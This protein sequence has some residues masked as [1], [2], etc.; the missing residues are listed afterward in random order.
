[1]VASPKSSWDL[2]IRYIRSDLCLICAICASSSQNLYS[3]PLFDA[4]S[5]AS[6][7]AFSFNNRHPLSQQ[8]ISIQV[9]RVSN[10]SIS[11]YQILFKK[12]FSNLSRAHTSTLIILLP[13]TSKS[14]LF[15]IIY[16]PNSCILFQSPKPLLSTSLFNSSSLRGLSNTSIFN[17]LT[18]IQKQF[19]SKLRNLPSLPSFRLPTVLRSTL[20]LNASSLCILFQSLTPFPSTYLLRIFFKKL[21]FNPLKSNTY[22]HSDIF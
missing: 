10:T 13:I 20:T 22:K 19:S 11:N 6:N 18:L 12:L 15:P 7:C 4:W 1:M 14:E 16:A 8:A 5:F 3:L 9:W 21:Y 2:K 17:Y